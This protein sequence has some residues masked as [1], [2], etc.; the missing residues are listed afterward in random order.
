MTSRVLMKNWEKNLLPTDVTFAFAFFK[1]LSTANAVKLWPSDWNGSS[2]LKHIFPLF[3]TYF[4]YFGPKDLRKLDFVEKAFEMAMR[5]SFFN[6]HRLWNCGNPELRVLLWDSL[7]PRYQSRL[8]D[9]KSAFLQLNITVTSCVHILLDHAHDFLNLR[10][11]LGDGGK[12]LG[13]YSDQNSLS[14]QC[15]VWYL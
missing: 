14:A 3:W 1:T 11:E 9:F 6:L 7:S 10:A 2:P 8:L 12:G 5:S 13:Y 15:T 4:V